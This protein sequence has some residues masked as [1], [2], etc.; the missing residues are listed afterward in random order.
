MSLSEFGVSQGLFVRIQGLIWGLQVDL[1]GSS[2]VQCPRG[3]W[4]VR[5]IWSFQS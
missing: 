5:V 4:R 2:R 3:C 1:G